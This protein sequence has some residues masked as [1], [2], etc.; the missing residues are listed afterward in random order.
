[1]PSDIRIL[2]LADSHLGFDL[3]VRPRVVRRRR[4]HDFLANYAAAL[5]PALSG[6]VDLVVHGGDVFDYPGIPPSLAYQ[7][8][9]PLVEIA[10]R[11]VPVF[12][13]PGNHE[14][15]RLPHDR[16]ATH[17]RIHIFDQPRT[18]VTQI[19]GVRIALSGF[20]FERRNVRARFPELLERTRWG[21]ESAHTRLLCMHQCVEGATVGPANFTFTAAPDVV[22]CRDIPGGFTAVLCGHIHRRQAL[23]SDLRRRALAT[24]V[25]YPGSLERTSLAEIAEPK[26]YMVVSVILQREGGSAHWEFRQLYSRPMIVHDV[27]PNEGDHAA[28]LD[29]IAALIDA[30]P[31]DAVLRLRINGQLSAAH[32]RVLTAAQLRR[33]APATMNVEMVLAPA[34]KR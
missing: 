25:L 32:A 6:E 28:L 18:F 11:G 14:R 21:N 16:F 34:D 12:I 22:R 31:R 29:A 2:L 19:R 17:R 30:A 13:V 26:G 24:P 3:P 4:G 7:A 20:P 9:A 8:Y 23:T 33:L 15:S 5:K 10:G 1:M 27:I